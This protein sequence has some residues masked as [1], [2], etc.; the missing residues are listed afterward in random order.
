[1]GVDGSKSYDSKETVV[2]FLQHAIY[3]W[4]VFVSLYALPVTP[5]A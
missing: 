3:A 4:I 1:V 5:W 2:L